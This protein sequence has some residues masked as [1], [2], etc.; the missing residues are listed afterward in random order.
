[1]IANHL[2]RRKVEKQKCCLKFF[3]LVAKEAKINL[4]NLCDRRQ[5]KEWTENLDKKANVADGTVRA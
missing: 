2:K 1:M 5:S 3:K 4:K